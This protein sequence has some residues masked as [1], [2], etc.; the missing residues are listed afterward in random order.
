VVLLLAVS[1][2]VVAAISAVVA[3]FAGRAAQAYTTAL[4]E[5]RIGRSQNRT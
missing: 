2:A 5:C 4:G 1:V 3:L